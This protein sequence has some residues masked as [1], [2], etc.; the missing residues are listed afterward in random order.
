MT[1]KRTLATVVFILLLSTSSRGQSTTQGDLTV[2]S[3]PPGA[4][5]ILSGDV[6]VSGVTPARFRHLLIG[7]YKLTVTK[8]GY[9]GYNTRLVLDPSKQ[10]A[11]DVTLP[12]KT[13]F[14]ALARSLFI[15]GWGQRYTEQNKKS[16]LLATLTVGAGISYYFADRRFDNKNDYFEDRLHEYDSVAVHGNIAELRGLK[17]ELDVAQDEAYSAE[18]VRRATIGA[19]A[20]VWVINI[21]DV[22]FFFPE[23]R[24][25]FSVKGLTLKPTTDNGMVGLAI[26][27]EF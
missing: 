4:Q 1:L 16:F 12:A 17:H 25:S 8:Y 15:P 23:E 18:N 21:V 13:R 14:K 19:I 10:Q 2:R 27:T 3:N 26:T 6:T 11:V 7:D 22:L 24:G 20:A 9:E 5:V